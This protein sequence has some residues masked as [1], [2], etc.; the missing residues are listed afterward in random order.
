MKKLWTSK[1]VSVKWSF[2][3]PAWHHKNT[4]MLINYIT[5]MVDFVLN[6]VCVFYYISYARV[7]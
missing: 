3:T 7:L 1:T 2:F 6:T 5:C 4:I